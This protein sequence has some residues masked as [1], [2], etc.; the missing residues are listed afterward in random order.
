MPTENFQIL[1]KRI[2]TGN[3][4][5][6]G[7][8]VSKI[9]IDLLSELSDSSDY[10]KIK[11]NKEKCFYLALSYLL[12]QMEFELFH[13]LF[14]YSDKLGFF[15]EVKKI[16][17]RF[18]ILAYL[19][20]EGMQRGLTGRIFE[21]IRHFNKYNLFEK[22]F[23]KDHT[24]IIEEIKKKDKLLIANLKDLFGSA[25]DS[26]IYY[27]CK[28]M[29]YDLYLRKIY[30]GGLN[31]WLNEYYSIYGLVARNLGSI[32]NFIDKIEKHYT[33]IKN[34]DQ[35]KK[36]IYIN[37]GK[38]FYENGVSQEII[39]DVY[40]ENVLKYKDD[41]LKKNNYN[42]YSLSMV[43]RGGLGPEGFGFT[44]STPRGEVIEICSDQR[45]SDAIIIKFK[46]YL[47]NKFL[48]KLEKEMLDSEIDIG[49]VEKIITFLLDILK[50]EALISYYNKEKILEK[51]KNFLYQFEEFQ[52]QK[53]IIVE[54]V[55]NRISVAV[56]II[57][58]KVRLK[59][60]FITR[61][62]LLSQG[63]IKSEEIANLTK[64]F[65]Y[66]KY[67]RLI[68]FACGIH[69]NKEA[70]H[71]PNCKALIGKTHYDL[72]R[73]RMFFQNEIKWYTK[74]YSDKIPELEDE[75]YLEEER[76]LIRRRRF[77]YD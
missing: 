29:P 7:G 70:A 9:N 5:M 8:Y 54:E 33:P 23:T 46:E 74:D 25:S 77:Y 66:D 63:K 47:K 68:C 41:I 34:F 67:D 75:Y 15:I 18:K 60:Q 62:D 19:H 20:L 52:E 1:L 49:I 53:E 56:S 3:L 50:S 32:R 16:P 76:D 43:L 40:P 30:P 55:L 39:H 12:F 4:S 14:N 71:C 31:R 58:R 17:F 26:L 42:F 59:D 61:M 65:Y 51:V 38:I 64:K 37:Y 22:E 45:Q 48:D 6:F 27:V 21:I 13:K 35:T 28:I 10:E 44:Y 11:D 73:E 24:E 72:L 36:D 2:R 69:F 57:L